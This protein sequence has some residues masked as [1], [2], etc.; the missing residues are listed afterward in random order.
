MIT[1]IL[2]IYVFCKLKYRQTLYILVF[3]INHLV[4]TFIRIVKNKKI[5]KIEIQWNK[6]TFDEIISWNGIS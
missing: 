2:K 6:I 4:H 3:W 5:F 1:S